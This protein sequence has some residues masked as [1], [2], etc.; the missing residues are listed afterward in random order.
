MLVVRLLIKRFHSLPA[1]SICNECFWVLF[2]AGMGLK[3]HLV[4]KSANVF[5]G[6]DSFIKIENNVT[7]YFV[8]LVSSFAVNGLDFFAAGMD[9][10]SI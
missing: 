9:R 8:R 2:T 1:T 3:A 7:F 6:G 10:R 4:H 5:L